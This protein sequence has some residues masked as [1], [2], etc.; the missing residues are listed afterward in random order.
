MKTKLGMH[1]IRTYDF[2]LTLG[3]FSIHYSVTY[4]ILEGEVTELI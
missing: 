4:D 3:R 2:D 1:M